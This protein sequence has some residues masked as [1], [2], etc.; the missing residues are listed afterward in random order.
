[1][2]GSA[3][4]QAAWAKDPG[5]VE[6]K[7]LPI[8]VTD[9][10]RPA[11]DFHWSSVAEGVGAATSGG[12]PGPAVGRE[13]RPRSRHGCAPSLKVAG[14]LLG[15]M[16]RELTLR[17]RIDFVEHHPTGIV[18]FWVPNRLWR[19]PTPDCFAPV[20]RRSRFDPRR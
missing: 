5:G 17:S 3:E 14:R 19:V 6:R 4:W 10:P 16:G 12:P 9:C 7:F 8:R 13:V 1:V 18:A 15:A 11:K 20:R 2:F